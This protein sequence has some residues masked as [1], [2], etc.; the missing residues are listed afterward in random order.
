MLME[1]AWSSFSPQYFIDPEVDTLGAQPKQIVNLQGYVVR[2]QEIA[3]F[4]DINFV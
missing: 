1:E 3:V 2:K 4:L